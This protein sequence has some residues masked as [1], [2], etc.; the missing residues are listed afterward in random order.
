MRHRHKAKVGVVV[1]IWNVAPY[2]ERCAESLMN[3]TLEDMQFVFVDDASPDESVTILCSVLDRF[4]ERSAQVSLVHHDYNMGLPSARKTGLAYINADYVAHCDSDDW[5]EPDMYEKLY[6]KGCL[7]NADIVLCDYYK[8]N[9]VWHNLKVSDD[10][11]WI[12]GFL[13]RRIGSALWARITRTEIY[14]QVEFPKENYLEDWVQAVQTYAYSKVVSFINEPLYHY[15]NNETSITKTNSLDNCDDRLRQC[16][17]NMKLVHDFVIS[18]NLA[19]EE[20]LVYMKILVRKRLFPKLM[21]RDGRRQYLDTYPEL[22]HTLFRNQW[23][24]LFYKLE[25]IAILLNLYPEWFRYI[26]P[27]YQS[28]KR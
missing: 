21:I 4:P 15:C 3:Q 25:H 5:V 20:D 1:P 19:H 14:R 6:L 8:N 12:Q 17:A 16:M 7:N 23:V 9:E 11:D 18:K 28:L 27:I 26:K 10:C 2:I 22:N 13:H 24:P